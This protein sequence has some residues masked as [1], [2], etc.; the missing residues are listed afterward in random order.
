MEI[1]KRKQEEPNSIMTTVFGIGLSL[2]VISSGFSG[3]YCMIPDINEYNDLVVDSNESHTKMSRVRLKQDGVS[4]KI[5]VGLCLPEWEKKRLGIPANLGEHIDVVIKEIDMERTIEE[6]GPFDVIFHKILKWFDKDSI[7]GKSYL[8]KLLGYVNTYRNVKLVDP[9]ENGIKLANRSLTLQLAKRCEFILNRKRIFVPNFVF[10][11]SNDT[12]YMREEIRKAGIKY[13]VISKQQTGIAG[14]TESHEMRIVFSEENVKDLQP[15]CVVQEFRNHGGKMFKVYI[16]GD[17]FYTC[18]KPSVRNLKA[19]NWETV[20]FDSTNITKGEYF[21]AL[22]EQDPSYIS[23]ETSDQKELLDRNL[24]SMLIRKLRSV[25]S[26]NIL[27]IDIII[28]EQTGNYGIVDLNYSPSFHC[29][30]SHFPVDL[31]EV[32]VSVGKRKNIASNQL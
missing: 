2:L 5:K 25:L 8:N 21:P 32:F 16:I 29:V 26:F 20:L 6:Q 9:I 17:K 23:F 4:T 13:P 27:G 15:P 7:K 30:S 10:L 18:E 12:G 24:I 3:V 11:E 22:H 19:G 14:M 31:V 1:P 28:D